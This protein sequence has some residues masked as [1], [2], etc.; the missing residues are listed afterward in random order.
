MD[1][2]KVKL[3]IKLKDLIVSHV[4]LLLLLCTGFVIFFYQSRKQKNFYCI[5]KNA[6][7]LKVSI[8]SEIIL[9]A[10]VIRYLTELKRLV[11]R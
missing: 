4:L 5:F 6:F 2:N 10:E 7:N 3:N 1:L 9:L 8:K 11:R